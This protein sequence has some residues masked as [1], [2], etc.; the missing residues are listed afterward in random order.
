[1]SIKIHVQGRGTGKS[2]KVEA[3]MENLGDAALIVPTQQIKEQHVK[4]THDP[5]KRVFG[6]NEFLKGAAE[7]IGFKTYIID[8]GLILDEV[9]MAELYYYLGSLG[10]DVI[11]YGSRKGE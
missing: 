1:M 7:G 4:G 2:T 5:E 10:V 9:T 11:V 3:L 8:E 6:V